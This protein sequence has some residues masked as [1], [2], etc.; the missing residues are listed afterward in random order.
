MFEWNFFGSR[1]RI[2]FR[3]NKCNHFYTTF[4]RT[5]DPEHRPVRNMTSK[6]IIQ[7]KTGWNLTTARFPTWFWTSC[8]TKDFARKR[9]CSWRVHARAVMEKTVFRFET[10]LCQNVCRQYEPEIYRKA[11]RSRARNFS[12]SK[13][14]HLIRNHWNIV[15]IKRIDL[16]FAVEVMHKDSLASH[17][18]FKFLNRLC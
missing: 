5:Y 15:S 2:V 6:D 4:I 17:D 12:P 11:A 7:W 8:T 1:G 3:R 14:V 10:N 9:D 13:L 16:H 18:V